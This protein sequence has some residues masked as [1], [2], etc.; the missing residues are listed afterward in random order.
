M[1]ALPLYEHAAHRRAANRTPVHCLTTPRVLFG[2]T[3]ATTIVL[4][5][6]TIGALRPEQPRSSLSEPLAALT[7]FPCIVSTQ[8]VQRAT[9][10]S[11]NDSRRAAF[12]LAVDGCMRGMHEEMHRSLAAAGSADAAFAAAMIPHHRGALDMARQ[13][14]LSGRDPE[15]R[16]F[17]LNLIAEQQAEIDMLVSWN[18]RQSPAVNVSDS[19]AALPSL[20]GGNVTVRPVRTASAKR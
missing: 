2:L 19:I 4:V 10:T 6:T 3:I 11:V 20:S 5:A 16:A 18:A 13:L 15:L 9:G 8:R 14:L 1:V 17:A 7:A 12:V